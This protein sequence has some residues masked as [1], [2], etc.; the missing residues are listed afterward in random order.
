MEPGMKVPTGSRSEHFAAGQREAAHTS[1]A[2]SVKAV[3]ASNVAVGVLVLVV[4]VEAEVA[5][6]AKVDEVAARM[7]VVN[8]GG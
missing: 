8:I 3:A 4:A 5:G 1:E 2:G 7:A 6:V